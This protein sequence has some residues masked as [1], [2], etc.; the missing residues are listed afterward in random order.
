MRPA[1]GI[2]QKELKGFRD[3]INRGKYS[4]EIAQTYEEYLADVK[5][6]PKAELLEAIARLRAFVP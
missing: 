4:A 5:A 1:A 6:W 3:N 2:N